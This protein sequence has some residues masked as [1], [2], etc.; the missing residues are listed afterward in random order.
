MR[1]F[2]QVATDMEAYIVCERLAIYKA[3]F[4]NAKVIRADESLD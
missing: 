4:S 3:I 2:N 1:N